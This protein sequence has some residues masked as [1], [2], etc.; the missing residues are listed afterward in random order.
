M[1]KNGFCIFV[2][3]IGG[4]LLQKAL[5]I[6]FAAMLKLFENTNYTDSYRQKMY[7]TNIKLLLFS[8][9]KFEQIIN[10]DCWSYNH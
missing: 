3:E 4:F 1:N 2:S 7:F 6:L 9:A 10:F 8:P 5:Y